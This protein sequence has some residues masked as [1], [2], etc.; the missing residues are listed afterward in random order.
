MNKRKEMLHQ[1]ASLKFMATKKEV[2]EARKAAL[3]KRLG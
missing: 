3:L 2:F 1:T